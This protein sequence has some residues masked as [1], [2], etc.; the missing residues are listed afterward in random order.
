MTEVHSFSASDHRLMARALRLAKRGIYTAR[1]NPNVGC[2]LAVGDEVVGEGWHAETGGLHAEAAALQQ[3]GVKANGATAYVTLEPC[4]HYGRT[5]PCADALIAQGVSR[6]IAATRDPFAAVAGR[7]VAALERAGITT[8][9][10]LMERQARALNRGYFSRVERG[11][12]FVTLK[13][14]TS[15][16]GAPAMKSG[17]SQWI[18]GNAA[19][20]D[21]HRLRASSGA[22]LTGVGTVLADDPSLTVREFHGEC[23]QPLRVIV[24]STLRTPVDAK[25]IGNDANVLLYCATEERAEPLRSAGATVVRVAAGG[26]RHLKLDLVLT[27][28]AERGVN[29]VLVEAG[30]A[31]A[32]QLLDHE[33]IDELVIYL[34]PHIMGSQTLRLFDTPG[35]E[36]LG[37]RQALEILG[38]RRVGSDL[39]VTARPQK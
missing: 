31:L 36:R 37:D 30:P 14:A 35:R 13:L 24:D 21:V 11:R 2:V 27:D 4:S 7:G 5:P 16:D 12:P 23:R 19:R 1:P 3:A 32:G 34:A 28:L 10:G 18:T 38:T 20:R 22:L 6:V 26:E 33:L 8:Q 15:M 17:E 39:R 29:D 25:V 9:V